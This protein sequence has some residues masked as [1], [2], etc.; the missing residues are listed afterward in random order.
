MYT[1]KTEV[2]AKDAVI[3]QLHDLESSFVKMLTNVR[4][5]FVKFGCDLP[6]ARFFLSTLLDTEE[7]S[8][9][10]DFD[11]LVQQLRRNYVSTFNT[12]YL[13]KLATYFRDDMLPDDEMIYD[14]GYDHLYEL[15]GC[16]SS[17]EAERERFLKNT[18]VIEFQRAVVS[19]VVQF[20]IKDLTIKVSKRLANNRIL[21]DTEELA[22]MSFEQHDRVLVHIHVQTV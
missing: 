13:L 22:L 5:R 3:Q 18:S 11:E 21:K 8:Q 6:K 2:L 15:T 4:D 1:G 9:C 10:I 16:I 12:V 19:S 14:D 7:F 17:Y 20:K